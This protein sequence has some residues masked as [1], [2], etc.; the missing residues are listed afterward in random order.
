MYLTKVRGRVGKS[1]QRTTVL[2]T[3]R[4]RRKRV[5][6]KKRRLPARPAEKRKIK[7]CYTSLAIVVTEH[8]FGL[9]AGSCCISVLL[10]LPTT[11]FVGRETELAELGRLLA[12]GAAIA[13][14]MAPSTRWPR[15]SAGSR[16]DGSGATLFVNAPGMR[17][18][19]WIWNRSVRRL[20]G[21]AA[22]SAGCRLQL[23]WP[24]RGRVRFRVRRLR[25]HWSRASIQAIAESLICSVGTVKWYT[26]Q[27]YGKLGVKSRTQAVARARELGIL[28]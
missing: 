22:S 18:T 4:R 17:G 8:A 24:P 10:P 15:R 20:G 3:G 23:N 21:S 9:F 26:T 2:H 7:V 25:R 5:G 16:N 13:S 6:W 11:S 14:R 1:T 28:E 19:I 27:I 12:R